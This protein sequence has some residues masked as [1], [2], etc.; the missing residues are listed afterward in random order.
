MKTICVLDKIDMCIGQNCRCEVQFLNV[1][2]KNNNEKMVSRDTTNNKPT[3]E[4]PMQAT[5]KIRKGPPKSR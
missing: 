2:L 3:F 5:N 1:F 4:S